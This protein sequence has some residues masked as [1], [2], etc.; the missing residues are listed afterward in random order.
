MSWTTKRDF[1]GKSDVEAKLRW[2]AK[3]IADKIYELS[4]QA[5]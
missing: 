1:I 5:A 3:N 2:T 4:Y